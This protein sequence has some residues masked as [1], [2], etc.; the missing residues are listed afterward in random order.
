VLIQATQGASGSLIRLLRS[1]SAADFTSC[2]IPHL[3]IELPHDIDTPTVKFLETFQWPPS[4]VKNRQHVR[5]LSLRH[6]IPRARLTEEESSVR[7]LESFWPADP[8][9]SHVLVLSPQAELSPWFYHCKLGILGPDDKRSM[10][11]TPY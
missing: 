8:K 5:Q 1:L 10:L 11:K 2:S 3:T 6:R 4:H 7:F 9:N